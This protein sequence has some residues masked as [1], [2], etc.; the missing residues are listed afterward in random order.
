MAKFIF[1]ESFDTYTDNNAAPTGILSRWTQSSHSPALAPGRFLGK[2]LSLDWSDRFFRPLDDYAQELCIGF[3]YRQSTLPSSASTTGGFVGFFNDTVSSG[4][5]MLCLLFVDADGSICLNRQNNRDDSRTIIGRSEPNVIQPGVWNFIE[6]EVRFGNGDGFTRVY[7]NGNP[8]PV[9]DLSD[10][11]NVAHS[12]DTRARYLHM[13]GYGGNS[14]I[15]QRL[16]DDVY[17]WDEPAR[18]GPIRIE[19]LPVNGNGAHQDFTPLTGTDNATM[20]DETVPNLADYVIGTAP[21]QYDEYTLSNL[22]SSA[23]TIFEVNLIMLAQQTGSTV[24]AMALGVE[25]EGVTSLGEDIYMGSG[26]ARYERRM[27]QRPIEIP[28]NW[29]KTTVDSLILRPTITV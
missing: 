2:S 9:L 13:G 6:W 8:T 1:R 4:G 3:S 19:S 18:R 14:S 5:G 24:R 27:Q 22:T 23:A 28:E 15:G 7:L 21:G 10:L 12:G 20:I 16:Y 26:F 17:V 29:T 25:T 11:D